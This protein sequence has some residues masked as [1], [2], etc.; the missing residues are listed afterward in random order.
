MNHSS[1]LHE[2]PT[3]TTTSNDVLDYLQNKHATV[4]NN[5]KNPDGY[6]VES[7]AL[8]AL[9]IAEILIATEKKP[10]IIEVYEAIE[11]D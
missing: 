11:E 8:L 10:Y 2:I 4:I 3:D 7:C 6:G 9:R 5:Y 1:T